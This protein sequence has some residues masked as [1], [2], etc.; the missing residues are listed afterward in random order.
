[1]KKFL[2]AFLIF[3]TIVS[4]VFAGGSKEKDE[5]KEE[6][7][8]VLP[9]S[10]KSSVTTITTSTTVLATVKLYSETQIT[11]GMVDEYVAAAKEAGQEVTAQAALETL[12]A[13]SVY[14]QFIE[15]EAKKLSD[16]DL[17]KYVAQAAL[18]VAS[19]Y[20]INLEAD[21]ISDFITNTLGYSV[22]DF[23]NLVLPQIIAEKALTEKYADFINEIITNPTEEQIEKTYNDNIDLFKVN[24]SVRVAHIF[25]PITDNASD[26]ATKLS[27]MTSIK[28]KLNAGTLTFE[29]AVTD[30]SQDSG[31]N[32]NG[33]VISG[34]LEKDSA[35]GVQYFGE[36]GVKA[37]FNLAVGQISNVIEGP[38]GY[39][40]FKLIA[41]RDAYTLTINDE[42]AEGYTV[43]QFLTE[44]ILEEF[45]NQALSIAL[46]D[47]LLPELMEQAT[48][49]RTGV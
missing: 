18:S 20:G 10:E 24:E 44:A 33:G 3:L 46:N 15:N 2:V 21:Q 47:K 26:N 36:D 35:L 49:T 39:H 31:S 23:A 16:D 17:Q 12:I 34:W 27:T 28:A 40:I 13:Q 41:H 30:Y 29:K 9:D 1:M 42:Y 22:Q 38:S 11:K 7:I 6:V 37:I 4:P 14:A 19:Q 43:K 48:I 8:T 45:Y 25:M 5:K 32:T